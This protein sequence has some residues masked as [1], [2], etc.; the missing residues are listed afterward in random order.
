MIPSSFAAIEYQFRHPAGTVSLAEATWKKNL[1]VTGLKGFSLNKEDKVNKTKQ[2][3]VAAKPTNSTLTAFLT[4]PP[5]LAKADT[6][7][8]LQWCADIV[9]LAR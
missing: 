4:R 3:Q 1:K 7:Q 8:L 5:E 2:N 6:E 9:A